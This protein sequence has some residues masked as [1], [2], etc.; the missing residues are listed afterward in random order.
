MSD[1]VSTASGSFANRL[2][3]SAAT[4]SQMLG[5]SRATLYAWHSSGRLGPLPMPGLG[6]RSLWSREE[7]ENWV[8][9]GCPS[10]EKWIVRAGLK[11][12]RRVE[13]D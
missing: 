5:V 1:Q 3:V 4:V 10:R 6:R 11:P 2:L 12:R 7:L 8:R 9:A 13:N